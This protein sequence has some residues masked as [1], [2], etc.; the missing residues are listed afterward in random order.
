MQIAATLANEY[1]CEWELAF[2][3]YANEYYM[4]LNKA[5]VLWQT[6]LAT[7]FGVDKLSAYIYSNGSGDGATQYIEGNADLTAWVKEALGYAEYSAGVL[8]GYKYNAS[9]KYVR[10]SWFS[11]GYIT[12]LPV[13]NFSGKI[14]SSISS[15]D[16]LLVNELVYEDGSKYAYAFVN[17]IDVIESSTS[18]TVTV[19]FAQATTLDFIY[20]GTTVQK[21]F[22]AGANTFTLNAGEMAIIK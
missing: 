9:Q 5:R 22:K 15:T 17:C 7:A 8:T 6:N 20:N 12:S 21:T 18:I 4:T 14:F 10:S 11:G 16:D 13:K 1:G 19:N 3:T 2:Q